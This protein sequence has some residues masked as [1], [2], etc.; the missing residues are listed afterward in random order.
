MPRIPL[1]L[2]S[3]FTEVAVYRCITRCV[4]RAFPLPG[5]IRSPAGTSTTGN[6]GF[7][8]GC[9]S[10][11]RWQ[12]LAGQFGIDVLGVALMSNPIH[13]IVRNR[14]DVMLGCFDDQAVRIKSLP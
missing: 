5:W 7:R 14:P 12:F 3:D 10:W 11:H 4:R 2:L 9:S 13:L 1:K 8:I 6:S